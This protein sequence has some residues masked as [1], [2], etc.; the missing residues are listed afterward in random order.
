MSYIDYNGTWLEMKKDLES[1]A[2]LLK[3]ACK[4]SGARWAV[5]LDYRN[6]Q[7]GFGSRQG[8]NRSRQSI[9][10]N[11]VGTPTI[12][13]WLAGALS[14]GYVRWS[15][16]E[17]PRLDCQRIYVFPNPAE[18]LILM[19]G[20]DHV[21]KNSE[22]IFK[23]ISR[24]FPP[25][26]QTPAPSSKEL[27]IIFQDTQ[28]PI[29]QVRAEL[30]ASYNPQTILDNILEFL[31]GVVTCDAAYL[32]IRSGDIL[33]IQATW[34][35]QITSHDLDLSI[36]KIPPIE[37]I[38]LTRQGLIL[39]DQDD[40]REA[41]LPDLKGMTH[42]AWMGIPI[43]IGK[44]VIGLVAFIRA[45]T[46][47]NLNF[48]T[49]NLRQASQHVSSLAYNVENAIVYAEATRYLQQLALLNE[50]AV[51][52]SLSIEINEVSRRVMQ[53]LRRAFDT[54]WA[55]VFLISP[56][57]EVLREY[58]GEII[59]GIPLEISD[60]SSI[61]GYTV[62][63]GNPF[64][65][66]DLQSQSRFT[67]I[68][69]NIRSEMAV[70]LRYRGQVIG[71]IDLV[72]TNPNVY[73]NQDEQLLILIAGNLA[74]LFENMRLNEEL[75]LYIRQLEESQRALVQAEKM[76][77][78]G[79]LTASIAHEINNPLQSVSNCVHLA[80]RKELTLEDRQNYLGLAREEL[81]RLMQ[82]VQRMLDYYRPGVLDRKPT[83]IHA[84][85]NK[86]I[87]LMEK[88]FR[89]HSIRIHLHYASYLPL[90]YVVGDQI[91]QV[92]LNLALN[93]V[94]AMPNGG[95][96]IIE[97]SYN[98]D[99]ARII[100]Q[101]TGPGVSPSK[102]KTI[103]EPFVSSKQGGT[104][105]GLAISY[106]IITAHGG[107]LELLDEGE[108]AAPGGDHPAHQKGAKFLITLRCSSP[109]EPRSST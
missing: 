81:D 51:T 40:D 72:S 99:H 85:L 52:A 89:D 53:R 65:V 61:V 26:D 14:S 24:Y 45:E 11:L 108:S 35:C 107:S 10:N 41:L 38:I 60:E 55:A 103:F 62:Q 105:L 74:G 25:F 49:E 20:I 95:N 7:W 56:G 98:H 97:T 12:S 75:R 42:L 36:Q 17:D 70:P 80:E 96:L 47:T 67:P 23:I 94:E 15:K 63:S 9:L 50:L 82:T 29:W 13:S 86:V 48:D 66:N 91:Q 71:A 18:H 5:W 57:D 73:S 79:R 101:D 34:N 44:R 16:A 76:A 77:I 87:T 84:L 68:R 59:E 102:K 83:D 22:N 27:P 64:R 58:G 90:V 69:S 4:L 6:A 37:K 28:Q 32:A 1:S 100:F 8:L 21:D 93:A 109:T 46:F 78:A 88:Q 19:I 3:E 39:H 92:F 33:H 104:G 31:S 43:V 30:E 2:K 106:G 54:D